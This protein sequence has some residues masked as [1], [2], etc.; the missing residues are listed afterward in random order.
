MILIQ[1]DSSLLKTALDAENSFLYWMKHDTTTIDNTQYSAIQAKFSAWQDAYEEN[2]LYITT[3]S[4]TQQVEGID[5]VP[6]IN[7]R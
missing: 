6:V 2:D 5:R 3:G 4:G 7:P 1:L